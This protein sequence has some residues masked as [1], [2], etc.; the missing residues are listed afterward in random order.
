ML[1]VA[2]VLLLCLPPATTTPSP[3]PIIPPSV[4]GLGAFVVDVPDNYVS[5]FG[6]VLRTRQLDVDGWKF[7]LADD[8]AFY[9]K[10]NTLTIGG[11]ITVRGSVLKIPVGTKLNS[12]TFA[13][14]RVTI[15][16]A[17]WP[18]DVVLE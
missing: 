18:V 11:G 3:A 17:G 14:S 4:A 7:S 12:M 10:G 6:Q 1:L 16:L 2:V 13:D 15:D 8:C 9:V 5:L